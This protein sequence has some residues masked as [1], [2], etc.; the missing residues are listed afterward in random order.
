MEILSYKRYENWHITRA[1]KCMQRLYDL[2]PRRVFATGTGPLGC[3]PGELAL[4]SKNGD[5]DPDLQR[6]ATLFNTQLVRIVDELNSEVGELVFIAVNLF[7]MHMNIV[8]DPQAYG[9]IN[10]SRKLFSISTI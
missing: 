3:L 7:N 2:G 10:S 6:A 9:K 4:R 8:S 1:W 5:C